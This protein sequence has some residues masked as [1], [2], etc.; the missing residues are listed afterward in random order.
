MGTYDIL[1]DAFGRIREAVSQTL[2]GL[3]AADLAF[4]PDPGSNSIAWLVWHLT[5]VQDDHLADAF[6][7]AQ[8]WPDWAERLHLGLPVSDTGYRHT[9]AQVAQVVAEAPLLDGYHVAV[10]D[11]TVRLLSAAAEEDLQRIV[12]RSYDPPVTLAVRLV[13]VIADDLQHAGQAA[14]LR[15]L[16]ERSR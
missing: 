15:G 11:R 4:R 5:R 3:S 8:V 12:D 13:S 14:Y 2:A 7:E 10:H 16:I 9:P 1:I 6:G